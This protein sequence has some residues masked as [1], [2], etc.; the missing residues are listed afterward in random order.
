MNRKT[1]SI[2]LTSEPDYDEFAFKYFLLSLNK[3]Q[4]CYEFIFPE[5][6]D[7]VIRDY[8]R[9]GRHYDVNELFDLFEKDVKSAIEG[10]SKTKPDC[11][12]NVITASFGKNL[13]FWSEGNVAFI[14][15]DTWAKYF[16]PP[17]LFEYLSH[18]IID[19]LLFMEN[20]NL[21]SHHDT[22][23]CCLDYTYFKKDDRVDIA[24]GYICDECKQEIIN[25]MGK[26]YFAEIVH[27]IS[28]EW[29]GNINDFGSTAYNLKNFFSFDINK[30]S[31]FNKT[32]WEKTK[33]HFHEIPKEIIVGTVALTM[34]FLF[35]RFIGK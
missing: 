19:S 26:E 33:D 15:T 4:N 7:E 10:Y 24:L 8:Y 23:G 27:I 14:T 6:R 21:S 18:C 9:A 31:G 5:I 16:S 25:G 2:L 12:I 28:R 11:L 17:S 20:K 34:G 29:I 13:F 22:K 35:G 32:F 30:D 3:I 1:V